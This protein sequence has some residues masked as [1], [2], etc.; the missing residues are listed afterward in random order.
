MRENVKEPRL[1]QPI[2]IDSYNLLKGEVIA[3]VGVLPHG[4]MMSR[5][6]HCL[7]I[8]TRIIFYSLNIIYERKRDGILT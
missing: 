1:K 3:N 2:H 8:K 5:T 7:F 6:I 4:I